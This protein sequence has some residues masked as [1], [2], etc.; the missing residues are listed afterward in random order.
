MNKQEQFLQKLILHMN[1]IFQED[2][3]NHIS[4]DDLEEYGNEF[5]HV[6]SNMMPCYYYRAL[7]GSDTDVLEFNHMMN[8][9]IFQDKD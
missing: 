1:G 8:K 3:E 6:L 5:F 4:A 9:L 2:S 7:T